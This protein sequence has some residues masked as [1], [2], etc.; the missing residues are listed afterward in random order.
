MTRRRFVVLDRDGTINVERHYIREP[1]QIQL[2]PRAAEGLRRL[3]KLGL[4]LVV[5]TNQSAVGRGLLT[6][7]HLDLIH[8]QLTKLLQNEGVSLDG[9]YV[10][11][12]KPDDECPCRKPKPLL[13][14]L[15]STE[16]DFDP[17]SSFVIG[18]KPCDINLGRAVGGTT[19]LVRT[20]YGEQ[21]TRDSAVVSDYQV[22]DLCHAAEVIEA[23][24]ADQ[25]VSKCN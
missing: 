13:V 5:I 21:F 18:D 22:D 16:L 9:I 2:L 20:G 12:H 23:V 15:A 24:I 17:R 4:G 19:L 1:S 10:C 7:E 14:N 11:L 3:Q 6:I 25:S 8:E